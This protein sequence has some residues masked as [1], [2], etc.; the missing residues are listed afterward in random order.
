LL[1]SRVFIERGA[2]QGESHEWD[3]LTLEALQQAF[4]GS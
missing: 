4:F 3:Q 1:L 2:Q